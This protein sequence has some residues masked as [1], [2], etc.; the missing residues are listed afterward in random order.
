[1]SNKLP[2]PSRIK[3]EIKRLPEFSDD[4][5]VHYTK[6]ISSKHTA[7][8]KKLYLPLQKAV[9]KERK[10]RGIVKTISSSIVKPK[11]PVKKKKSAGANPNDY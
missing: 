9:E 3:E 6:I 7:K 11:T 4:L 10:A 8:E 5:L 2:E 1:M